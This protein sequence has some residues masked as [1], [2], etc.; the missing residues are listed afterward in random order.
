MRLYHNGM[1]TC[2]QQVRLVLHEK[3]LAYDST[4]LDLQKGE[5]FSPE[6]LVL[7]PAAVVPALEDQGEVLVESSLICAYLDDVYPEIALLPGAP[8]DRYSMGLL[9]RRIDE[10]LAPACGVITYAIGVRPVWLNQPTDKVLAMLDK[11]PSPSRREARRAVFVEGVRAPAFKAAMLAYRGVLDLAE[12]ALRKTQWLA[13]D[14]ISRAD[15]ALLPFVLRLVHLAQTQEIES[16]PELQ[17]WFA[18][19][20]ARPAFT[21][22]VSEW[23]PAPVVAGFAEAGSAVAAEIDEVM[24]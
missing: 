12:G 17:R 20:Q 1:S 13:G 16:R 24:A 6:Y 10:A 5:Q 11:M 7:N 14:T 23:I 4:L 3:N 18:T 15:C 19:M 22:A 8:L 21:R 9:I 2:S